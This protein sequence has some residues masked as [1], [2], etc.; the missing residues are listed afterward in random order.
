ME[1]N[2]LLT[3]NIYK[4]FAKYVSLNILSMIGLSCYILADTFFIA[5]GVGAQ[6]LT[7][8]NLVLP[9][10][11]LLTGTG[12]LLGMG[13]ATRFAILKGEGQ[14]EKANCMFTYAMAVGAVLGIIYTVLGVVFAEDISRLLGAQGAILPVSAEYLRTLMIYSCA[15]VLNNVLICFIRNDHAPNLAMAA[16][17]TASLTNVVLDYVFIFPLGMG[18]FGAALA[19]G[20]APIIS[21]AV[22]SLHFA[23]G[24]NSFRLQ[25]CK[26]DFKSIGGIFSLGFPSFVMEMSNGIV[27]IILNFVILGISGN[28]GVAAYG[29]VAN[30]ALVAVSVFTGE[31]QGIQPIISYNYGAGNVRNIKKTYRLALI[32]AL[33]LGILLY[34]SG[35]LFTDQ[36]VSVFNRDNDPQ[37]LS[38]ASRGVQ[39]Y[40]TVFLI[41]GINIVT[42]SFFSSTARPIQ[43]FVLSILRGFAAV[44]PFAAA[45]PA[46]FGLD[47]A[48]LCIPAAEAVTLLLSVIL[49]KK[50]RL[51][52][53]SAVP[54]EHNA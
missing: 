50:S 10:F 14:R 40:F 16:M 9:A 22:L 38:L 44:I 21:I 53:P 36:I 1:T 52:V 29:I 54:A 33:C 30:L 20:I 27:I 15:F 48:W 26:P 37:L 43:S 12:M 19:T 25:K 6:G 23:R 24:K 3:G 17:I 35:I 51:K 11:S 28:M 2:K 18:M 34:L 8:L 45:L 5:N 39:L 42:V 13:A 31:A 7:A 4:P 41:M 49:I 47:G 46:F 32:T